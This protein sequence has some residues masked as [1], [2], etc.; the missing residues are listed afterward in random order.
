MIASLQDQLP[1]VYVDVTALQ[2]ERGVFVISESF[3]IRASDISSIGSP[4]ACILEWNVFSS[5]YCLLSTEVSKRGC[6]NRF[7]EK[8]LSLLEIPVFHFTP[9]TKVCGIGKTSCYATDCFVH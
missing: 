3:T 2:N 6:G 8:K 7:G 9:S 1:G 4:P 5:S